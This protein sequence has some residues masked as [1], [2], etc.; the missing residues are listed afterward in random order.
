[1]FTN[2]FPSLGIADEVY[3]AVPIIEFE[4]GI[5]S[6]MKILSL[7]T[8]WLYPLTKQILCRDIDVNEIVSTAKEVLAEYR[9]SKTLIAATERIE[10]HNESVKL[11]NKKETVDGKLQLSQREMREHLEVF[12]SS[13]LKL[14]GK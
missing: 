4:R 12:L 9:K 1:M 10:K 8:H 13:R 3:V 5:S 2:R 6:T 7:N 14:L 11:C